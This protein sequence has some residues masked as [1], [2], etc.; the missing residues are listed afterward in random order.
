MNYFGQKK[1]SCEEICP[2]EK[3]ILRNPEE[4]CK[5]LYFGLKN[6]SCKQELTA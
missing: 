4:S 1:G 2:E 5:F 6:K 3:G